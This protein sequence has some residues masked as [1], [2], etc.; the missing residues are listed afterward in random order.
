MVHLPVD[1]G[2]GAHPSVGGGSGLEEAVDP[3]HW[4]LQPRLLRPGH[5]RPLGLAPRILARL[6]SGHL[7][8]PTRRRD[9]SC[10]AQLC[11][12][13][14]VQLKQGW[15][16]T[17]TLPLYMYHATVT[18][19]YSSFSIAFKSFFSLSAIQYFLLLQLSR[20]RGS[21]QRLSFYLKNLNYSIE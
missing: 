9:D 5:G 4:E 12:F 1:S 19:C 3:A 17:F 15:H 8:T 7:S 13:S 20:R 14:C 11:L 2:G 21:D 10:S 18:T 6:A 16:H